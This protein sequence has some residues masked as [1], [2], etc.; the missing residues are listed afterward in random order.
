MV[1]LYKLI[2]SIAICLL[3][4]FTSSFFTTASISTWYKDLNKPSFN[5]PNYLFGP[6]WTILYLLMGISLYLVWNNSTDKVAIVFFIIQLALNFLWSFLFFQ[7][8][9]PLLALI[10]ILVLLAFIIATTIKFYPISK[11]AAY[12]L[13]PYILWVSFATILN[14]SIY[15]LNR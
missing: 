5:P 14:F 6:V 13:I 12:L 3:V 9:N 1:T 8:K 2:I 4:G 10:E 15:W 11:T 7:L